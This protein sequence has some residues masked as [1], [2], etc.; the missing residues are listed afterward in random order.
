[1]GFI[2]WGTQCWSVS[3][4]FEYVSTTVV[5]LLIIESMNSL[6]PKSAAGDTPHHSIHF[7]FS[8]SL[9]YETGE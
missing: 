3:L 5:S 2:V 7:S 1:M 9:S 4:L 6:C 8:A